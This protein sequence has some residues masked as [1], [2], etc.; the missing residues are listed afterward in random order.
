MQVVGALVWPL[1]CA[2]RMKMEAPATSTSQRTDKTI[3]CGGRFQFT[4]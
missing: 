4:S 3:G 1:A 2:R